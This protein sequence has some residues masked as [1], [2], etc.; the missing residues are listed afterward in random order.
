MACPTWTAVHNVRMT[1]SMPA[2][3]LPVA[4]VSSL[5]A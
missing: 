5:Y 3:V 1:I 4:Y 2:H